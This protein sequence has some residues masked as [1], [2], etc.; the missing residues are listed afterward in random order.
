MPLKDLADADKEAL[1]VHCRNFITKQ[2][3]SCAEAIYQ[4]D[5]VIENAYEFIEG[6]CDIV[7]YTTRDGDD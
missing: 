4:S 1:L 5:W 3:I 6:V 2:S 7:G